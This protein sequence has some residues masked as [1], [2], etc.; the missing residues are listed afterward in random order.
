MMRA[1]HVNMLLNAESVASVVRQAL[2]HFLICTHFPAPSGIVCIIIISCNVLLPLSRLYI[3]CVTYI[4]LH[5]Q[6]LLKVNCNAKKFF[7][8]MKAYWS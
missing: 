6:L 2:V 3:T 8:H 4:A 1:A 5:F 7:A